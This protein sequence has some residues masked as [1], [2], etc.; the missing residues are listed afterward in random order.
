MALATV[1][2]LSARG[3]TSDR[4]VMVRAALAAARSTGKEAHEGFWLHWLGYVL[5]ELG[6]PGEAI[7]HYEEALRIYRKLDRR[8]PQVWLLI[9]LANAHFQLDQFDDGLDLFNRAG[10]ISREIGMDDRVE[11]Q[12]P[13]YQL[14]PLQ[15]RL[16]EQRRIGDRRAELG[17]LGPLTG[18]YSRLLHREEYLE[19]ALGYN[20]E[21]LAIS[22]EIGHR[23]AERK[24]LGRL[25]EVYVALGRPEEAIGFFESALAISRELGDRQA[26]G[27]SLTNLGN[28][29][30]LLG[31]IEKAVRFMDEALT[32]FRELGSPQA[33]TVRAT[34]AEWR[35]GNTMAWDSEGPRT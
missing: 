16:A 28:A 15:E 33:E 32:L 12:G 6:Q 5:Q 2:F 20:E 30:Y 35:H 34:L 7:S 22:R 9:R 21:G 4:V 25:G 11:F 27:D 19:E 14:G 29:W 10:E 26:E 31:R 3:Y 17:T 13:V 8:E 24:H 1:E 23:P 18:V